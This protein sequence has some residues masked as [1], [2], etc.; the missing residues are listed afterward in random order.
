MSERPTKRA[1]LVVGAESSGTRLITRL[2]I[3]GGCHG[4]GGHLQPF[5]KWQ[6]ASCPFDGKD[7]IVWRRSY[8]WSKYH[9]WPNL[10]LDLVKPLLKHGYRV[11]RVLV[12]TRNWYSISQSQVDP[13]N[14]HAPTQ[15]DA[16][17]N[18]Q[19]AY[20]E[21]F[22][23][24]SRLGLPYLPVAYEAIT[25]HGERAV[26]PLLKELGLNDRAPLELIRK[27]DDDKRYSQ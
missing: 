7:P 11:A 12:T 24:L 4:D 17:E 5:D 3:A 27:E 16:L 26:R 19:L 13:K 21:I 2:L 23:Q 15:E 10:K 14:R 6:A 8:P 22:T 1:F 18:V 20:C 25:C 9:H